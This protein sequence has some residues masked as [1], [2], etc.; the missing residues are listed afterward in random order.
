MKLLE[1]RIAKDG[2]VLD[3]DVLKVDSFV[4]HLIDVPFM[5]ECAKELV[6][7]YNGEIIT[8]VLTVEASGIG[9]ACLVADI[10]SVPV[11]FAKKSKSRNIA[12]DVYA[13]EVAS[14]THGN[15]NTIIVNKRFLSPEDRVL[16]VDDFL[17]TGN[18]LKG[19]ISICGDAGAEIAG[20][21]IIIEKAYQPGGEL[22]RKICRVESLARIASMSPEKGIKFI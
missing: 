7:L 18:A 12:E 2:I 5:S 21:G 17:A 15:V 19:L 4:N 10:I 14:Y 16:I 11:V 8:K 9:F 1:E 6:R 13:A 20:C 3:G 22:I